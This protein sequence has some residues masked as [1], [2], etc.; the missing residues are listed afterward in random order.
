LQAADKA[1]ELSAGDAREHPSDEENRAFILAYFGDHDGAIAILE[2]LLQTPYD[3][4]ITPALLRL[5][6]D[7][8]NLRSDPRFQ[9]LC[10]TPNK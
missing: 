2:K 5:D 7:W 10:E 4:P 1:G 3:H 9:K 8:D 6:P